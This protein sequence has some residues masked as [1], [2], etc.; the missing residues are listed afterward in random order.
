MACELN[1][2]TIQKRYFANLDQ[3]KLKTVKHELQLDFFRTESESE[4]DRLIRMTEEI[5]DSTGTV[6]RKLFAENSELKRKVL[7]LESRLAI[8]ERHICH[9]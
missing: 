6:R 8:L 1:D 7:D 3:T 5:R 2:Y 4:V 9:S